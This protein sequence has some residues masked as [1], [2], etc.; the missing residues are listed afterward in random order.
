MAD[1]KR[2]INKQVR[3]CFIGKKDAPCPITNRLVSKGYVQKNGG[4]IAFAKEKQIDKPTQY[5]H[6][7]SSWSERRPDEAPFNRRI[8]CGEL[9]V[10]MAETSGAVDQKK[11]SD[12]EQAIYNLICENKHLTVEQVMAEFDISRAT[13]FRDYAKIKKIT[14]AVYDKNESVWKL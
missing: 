13:V 11:L 8:Q 14:G 9:L 4:Y 12:R 1:N 3:E 5:W 6:L 7:I 2:V 10:W